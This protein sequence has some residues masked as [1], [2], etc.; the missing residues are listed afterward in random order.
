VRVSHRRGPMI[1]GS[2][3]EVDRHAESLPVWKRESSPVLCRIRRDDP[4]DLGSPAAGRAPGNRQHRHDVAPRRRWKT[5]E[6]ARG[7]RPLSRPRD[8]GPEPPHEPQRHPGPRGRQGDPRRRHEVPHRRHRRGRGL[9]ALLRARR[10]RGCEGRPERR[11]PCPFL[12]RDRPRS[13]RKAQGLRREAEGHL[14]LRPL[15][16]RVHG[17]R[18]PQDPAGGCAVGRRHGRGRRSVPARLPLVPIRSHRR[19]RSRCLRLDGPDPLRGRS[20]G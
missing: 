12:L 19:I 9:E 4:I 2:L 5:P 1:R 13:D 16:R 3:G 20:Q 6:Q 7:A 17:R 10:C 15:S 8:R 14:R 11:P 18:L